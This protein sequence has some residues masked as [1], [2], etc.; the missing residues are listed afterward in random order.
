MAD[1]SEVM[2][3]I[4]QAPHVSYPVLTPNLKGFHSAVSTAFVFCLVGSV[5]YMFVDLLM[6]SC[7]LSWQIAAGAQEVAIFG[8][9]SESFSR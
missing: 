3:G 8:A 7:N 2:A 5:L 6:L 1:H 9:A 4:R